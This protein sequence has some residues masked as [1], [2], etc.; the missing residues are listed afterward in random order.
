MGLDRITNKDV[1]KRKSTFDDRSFGIVRKLE[2]VKALDAGQNI[3]PIS[4]DVRKVIL[5]AERRKAEALNVLRL[6]GRFS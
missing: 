3:T 4:F 2:P 1:K 6:R 5:E